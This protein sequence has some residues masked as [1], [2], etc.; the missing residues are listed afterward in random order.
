LRSFER[1]LVG[2]KYLIGLLLLAGVG[3]NFVNVAL[4]YI[5][6]SPFAWNEE[7]MTFGLLFIVM[8][9]TVVATAFDENLKIDILVQIAPPP[10]QRAL[11][12]FANAVW[13]GVAIYLA[14]Q[15]WTVVSL[16]MRLGQKSMAMRLPTWIPHSFLL[17]AFVLSACAAV[18]A[19]VRELRGTPPHDPGIVPS[20]TA[21]AEDGLKAE[22]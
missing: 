16:M 10:V 11:R 18:F 9:G 22:R 14:T 4:R 21:L 1:A 19:I 20:A 15:S 2:L 7:A 13:A 12:V 8:A 3:L 6:G 5:W 17:G